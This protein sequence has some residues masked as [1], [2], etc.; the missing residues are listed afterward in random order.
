MDGGWI[1]A[2]EL[3]LLGGGRVIGNGWI[4]IDSPS[5]S[6]F[7][8]LGGGELDV[9]GG[10]L[11][12]RIFGG[13]SMALPD[14]INI[15]EEGNSLYLQGTLASPIQDVNIG[16]ATVLDIDENWTLAGSLNVDTDVAE[17]SALTGTGSMEVEG[18]LAIAASSHLR[19]DSMIR[20]ENTSVV[21]IGANSILELDDW[22]DADAGNTTTLAFNARLKLDGPMLAS[23][24]DGDI[25]SMGAAVEVNSVNNLILNGDLSLGSLFGVR[26]NVAGS[27]WLRAFGDV[28]VTGIGAIVDGALDIEGTADMTLGSTALLLVNGDL[29]LSA[30]SSTSGIGMIE[31]NPGGELFVEDAANVGVDVINEGDFHAGTFSSLTTAEVSGP[32]TQTAT[33][34]LMV[35]LAGHL[36]QEKDLFVFSDGATLAGTLHITL[37]N[38]FVPNVGDEFEVLSATDIDGTFAGLSGAPGFT[39]AYTPNSVVVTYQG[40][41][42][43]GDV[44]GDG[45]VDIDDLFEVVSAWGS[46]PDLPAPCPA[47][48]TLDGEVNVD[49]LF[50]V[51]TNWT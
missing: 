15:L 8:G 22:F 49:D 30:G 5:L 44:N 43:P 27:H 40:V 14:T 24:W 13:G 36:D 11:H 17:V 25:S 1:L 33:G 34:R 48:V 51:V 3:D 42:I 41:G 47:D 20:F 45:V 50:L 32:F 37:A 29:A 9:Q 31:V 16:S 39:V 18:D 35:A 7:N 21:T 26:S 10:D 12:I 28:S 6:A 19:V 46:C 23:H 4:D 2:E 38:G